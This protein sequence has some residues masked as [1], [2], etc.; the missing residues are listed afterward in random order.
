MYHAYNLMTV[1]SDKPSFYFSITRNAEAAGIK[2]RNVN[3]K[4]ALSVLDGL[5][6]VPY[7]E[8]ISIA[9]FYIPT[10]IFLDLIRRII[11]LPAKLSN[12]ISDATKKD[13]NTQIIQKISWGTIISA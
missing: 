13:G 12:S 2:C 10:K 5:K 3:A 8:K 9:I 6:A 1:S 11:L 7:L 4:E